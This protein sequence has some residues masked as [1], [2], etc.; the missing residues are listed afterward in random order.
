MATETC[1]RPDRD[2]MAKAHARIARALWLIERHNDDHF[3][4]DA[5]DD[6]K[7]NWGAV[8]SA[9]QTAATL[10]Q[11]VGFLGLTEPNPKS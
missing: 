5:S 4:L 8:G 11:I 9:F 1:N 7:P 6:A 2:E 3:G 10:E